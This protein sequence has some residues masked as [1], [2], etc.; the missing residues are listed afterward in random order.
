MLQTTAHYSWYRSVD[1]FHRYGAWLTLASIALIPVKLS[2]A[3]IPI[4][5]LILLFLFATGVR[6][7]PRSFTAISHFPILVAPLIGFFAVALVSSAFGIR[8][9]ASIPD[10]LS[11]LF[12]VAAIPAW[13][14]SW[15]GR[16]PRILLLALLSGQL[17][18]AIHSVVSAASPTALPFRLIGT[19]SES[20]QLAL[21]VPVTCA[22]MFSYRW[23]A[24]RS[25]LGTLSMT[26]LFIT[27][28]FI[29]CAFAPQLGAST[30]IAIMLIALTLSLAVMIGIR[31]WQ[32]GHKDL[33]IAAV[34]APLVV[35]ALVVNLKRGP[36]VGAF[37]GSLL[38]LAVYRRRWV[39]PGMLVIALCLLL[40]PIQQRLL[41]SRSDFFIAG[42]RNEIWSI[43]RELALR[44]PL[45]IGFDNSA[46]L[47][48][49]STEVPP[50]LTHFHN[51]LLNILVETGWLGL[52]AFVVW[53]V[54][55]LRFCFRKR[56][57]GQ[58]SFLLTGI[59]CAV[60]AWQIAG[61]LEYNFG[62]S[63]VLYVV[64]VL[65]T[66]ASLSQTAH[67]SEVT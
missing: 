49:F 46:F 41:A 3:L 12:F 42:G 2:L 40:E 26:F 5:A 65:L 43:G 4:I 58:W 28:S 31:A 20:G 44:F 9:S 57:T 35:A 18:A 8:P 52:A 45:G 1:L 37:L 53:I 67:E 21:V 51:N 48:T 32:R 27:T 25:N 50:E 55:V 17:F 24:G 56:A 6:A 38:F 64:Y 62:D 30:S 16:D 36:W 7:L 34:I 14:Q 19:V 47:R 61:G 63:E 54:A 11:C 66:V 60:L 59:G 39:L 10:L 22:L 13:H 29:L 23:E 15:T 33:V